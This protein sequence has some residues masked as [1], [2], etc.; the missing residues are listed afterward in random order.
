MS[1]SE[2]L[3][4]ALSNYVFGVHQPSNSSSIR[5][6]Y[7]RFMTFI[8][9]KPLRLDISGK[10]LHKLGNKLVIPSRKPKFSCLGQDINGTQ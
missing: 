8:L 3:H 6:A 4:P 2:D 5:V 1:S 9:A 10:T 7:H